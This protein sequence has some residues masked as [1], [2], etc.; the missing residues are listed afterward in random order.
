M[1]FFTSAISFPPFDTYNMSGLYGL[2]VGRNLL[3]VKEYCEIGRTLLFVMQL[4]IE[5]T[6]AAFCCSLIEGRTV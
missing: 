4:V 3:F 2:M 1:V 5:N 6:V